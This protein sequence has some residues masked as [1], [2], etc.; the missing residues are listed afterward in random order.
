MKTPNVRFPSVPRYRVSWASNQGKLGEPVK[1][2]IKDVYNFGFC[3]R[4]LGA[5]L[6]SFKTGTIPAAT[7]GE[8]NLSSSESLFSLPLALMISTHCM[9]RR[10]VAFRKSRW[11]VRDEW[12]NN[13]QAIHVDLIMIFLTLSLRITCTSVEGHWGELGQLTYRPHGPTNPEQPL[14]FWKHV[15]DLLW[16]GTQ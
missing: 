13:N 4:L 15:I 3:S 9:R 5:L 16:F 1:L 12:Y 14:P 7:R 11:S 6:A 8:E 10:S 2:K